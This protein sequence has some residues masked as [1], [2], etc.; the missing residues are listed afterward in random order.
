MEIGRFAP[1]T[2]GRA[3]PGTL[4]AGLLA[5]LDIRSRGGRFILRLEDIDPTA[6]DEANKQGILDDLTWFGLNWDD[7]VWQSS[8]TPAHE[9]ALD[10]LASLGLLYEC[11]CSRTA[12]KAAGRPSAAGG[13]VYP[14]TCRHRKI[15]DWRRSRE[16]L[17]VDLS[18]WTVELCDESG[19]DLGQNLDTA[20]GD[21]MV[22]RS[23]GGITYQLA[24]VV[25]DAQG[26]VNRVVRG[27]DL[28]ASTAT[29]VALHRLLGQRI[30]RYRHHLLLLE[31]QGGKLAKLHQ[32]I[33][34][35]TI[36]RHMT[37]D[38]VRGFLAYATGLTPQP[39]PV[40]MAQLLTVFD[41]NRVVGNDRTV[42]W[43]DRLVLDPATEKT[44]H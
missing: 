42:V 32:S 30:P 33:G 12:V 39:V 5:W 25:D 20:M 10:T 24:V 26:G 36:R 35:D 16:N 17:R 4:L 34:A 15:R 28:A 23:D 8:R 44:L 27:R 3:H 1:T 43:N 18:G 7:L 38:E 9:A 11:S 14:G 19:D 41:W 37:A 29:Q 6:R 31:P 22:R 40:S 13:W 2:S 21:P